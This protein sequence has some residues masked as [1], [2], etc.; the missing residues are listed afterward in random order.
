METSMRR[1]STSVGCCGIG[2]LC[3]HY[4]Y[5]EYLAEVDL[6][7]KREVVEKPKKKKPKMT[8][9]ESLQFLLRSEYLGCMAV[10][11][12][13]YGVCIQFSDIMFKSVVSHLLSLPRQC[14][15]C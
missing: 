3:S 12:I 7:G 5:T 15:H 8:F 2:M 4:I 14:C 13:S 6:P 9:R 10:L 11:V 1:V